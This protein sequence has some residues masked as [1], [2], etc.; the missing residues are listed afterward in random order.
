M[1]PAAKARCASRSAAEATTLAAA[2]NSLRDRTQLPYEPRQRL[3]T[4]ARSNRRYRKPIEGEVRF[5]KVSRALYSTDASVYQIEP[6]GVVVPKTRE[7]IIRIVE[8][9][10]RLR[11]PDH[12]A[13]RRHIAGRPSHRRRHQVDISKYYNRFSN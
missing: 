8:I 13:R 3:R 11:M 4:R 12:H 10:R 9:C 2:S 5:D 6:L 7:D 1:D